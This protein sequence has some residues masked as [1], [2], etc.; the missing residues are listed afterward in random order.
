MLVLSR[1]VSEEITIGDDIVITVVKIK[2]NVVRLG[3]TAPDDTIILR[4]DLTE[5]PGFVSPA[6]LAEMIEDEPKVLPEVDPTL[7]EMIE[8]EGT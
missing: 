4:S 8:G 3:I 1:K 6:K 7:M 2:G 5:R